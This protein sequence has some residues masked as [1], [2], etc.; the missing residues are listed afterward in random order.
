MGEL[1]NLGGS[2]VNTR[3]LTRLADEKDAQAEALREQA[4]QI[5]EGAA[6][7]ETA[8][9]GRVAKRGPGRP[10]KVNGVAAKRGPGRP[11]TRQKREGEATTR[12][13]PKNEQSLREVIVDVLG[14][15]KNG[16]TFEQIVQASKQAGYKTSAK[17][18][19]NIV[20]QALHKLIKTEKLVSRDK[21][22]K[23][24]T[25]KAA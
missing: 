16:L 14:K 10:A 18:F 15:S 1:N 3:E 7:I 21:E 23:S 5:R 17:N 8:V 19:D 20:Y 4:R 2:N 6:L 9:T 24:Y 12:R 25:M 11:P 22:S 13:R